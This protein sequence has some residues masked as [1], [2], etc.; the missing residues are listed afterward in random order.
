MQSCLELKFILIFRTFENGVQKATVINFFGTVECKHTLHE[1]RG[2][3]VVVR[4]RK[5]YPILW[6]RLS[7]SEENR[8]WIQ[9]VDTSADDQIEFFGGNIYNFHSQKQHSECKPQFTDKRIK[10]KREQ[11]YDDED[12]D[13]VE[14]DELSFSYE[15]V[16]DTE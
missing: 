7:L 16:S 2:L 5:T 12:T 11:K 14:F 10:L 13:P 15:S 3:F 8:K 6:P 4:L 1:V 9:F